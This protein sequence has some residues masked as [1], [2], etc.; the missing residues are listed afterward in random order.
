MVPNNQ[1]V[2]R[3]GIAEGNLVED[4]SERISSILIDELTLAEDISLYIEIEEALNEKEIMS[5]R[6]H[7]KTMNKE[8]GITS[9]NKCPMDADA[10]F[11]L[12]EELF[13]PVN[14]NLDGDSD[15]V[16]NYLQKL[17]IKNHSVISKEVIH[18]LF[19]DEA[20][21][22]EVDQHMMSIEDEC[23][24]NEI[25]NAATEKDIIDLRANLQS[26]AQSISVYERTF[27][28][29]E[30]LIDGELD[31]ELECLIREEALLN[32][33]LSNEINLH[34]EI[35]N[36][37]EEQDIMNLRSTLKGMIQNEYSHSFSVD[38]LDSYLNED[39][40][41]S[42][43]ALFEDELM[44]NPGLAADL[45]FHKEVDKAITE[46]E[47]MALRANLQSISH[48]Q[49]DQDDEKLG[50]VSPKRKSLFW[51]AAASV[52]VLMVVFTSLMRSKTYSNLQLYATYYQPYKSGES[53]SRSATTISNNLNVAL[54]EINLGQY[55]E[56]VNSLDKA[57]ATERDGFSVNF[58]SGV[59]YQE[60]GEYNRAISSFSEV[61]RHGD[62][63]L[64]EQS[65][66]YIGL[67]YLRIDERQKAMNQFKSIVSK[68][69]F[70]GEQSSKLLKKLE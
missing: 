59:A 30:D 7:L 39:L 31:N 62:N 6:S 47:I 16:G 23:L 65:E 51:Y 14:L 18:D 26:I 2:I 40:D 67:C 64:V 35:N 13:N 1:E 42:T 48:E 12:S 41:D 21:I 37:I 34:Y 68:N 3:E 63:L 33:A 20:A 28:E 58:Y 36:A 5:L 29:I 55:R 8:P 4:G 27:E 45:A 54:H 49:R 11:G 69:G 32:S 43:M 44:I 50:I 24:F 19:T 52:I 22:I 57:S 53:V 66:W 38:E 9:E 10:Y 56:A 25:G 61:V 17:H 46:S 15:E 60:L 70:Y